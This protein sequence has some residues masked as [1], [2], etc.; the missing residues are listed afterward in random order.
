MDLDT[1]E[2][3]A[4]AATPGPWRVNP[5]GVSIRTGEYRAPDSVRVAD[6]ADAEDCGCCPTEQGYA[7]A[8]YIAAASPDVVLALIARVRA[9]EAE[10]DR[11]LAERDTPELHDFARGVVLEATHQRQ[12]WGS[13]H[14]AGKAAADWFWLLGYL[15]G[16]ALS[17]AI[18]GDTDKALHHTISTAA[19]LANWHAALLGASTT[20]RPG[21]E[22]PCHAHGAESGE[23]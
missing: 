6:I 9:A 19:A 20:M 11:L 4:R 14:D 22:P 15:G 3:L 16:K 5:F 18:A 1:L 10:R 13:T 7:T 2:R 8:T 17:A 12:R 21:I 23:L